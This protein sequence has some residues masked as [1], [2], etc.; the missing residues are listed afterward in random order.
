MRPAVAWGR[1]PMAR[2][3]HLSPTLSGDDNLDHD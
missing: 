3:Q 1:I 2:S